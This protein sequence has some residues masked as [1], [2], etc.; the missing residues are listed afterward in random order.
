[1]TE[2]EVWIPVNEAIE[3]IRQKSRMS[4]GAAKVAL[5]EACAS[6]AVRAAERQFPDYLPMLIP[7]H[8][9]QDADIDLDTGELVAK[10][11]DPNE[12]PGANG[13]LVFNDAD[14]RYWLT[15]WRASS[16]K[17]AGGKRTRII[18]QLAE[19]FPNG[20][21]PEPGL[22][23]RKD[24]RAQLLERDPMLRPLDEETLKAS[25]NEFNAGR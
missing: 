24:L 12:R 4:I 18:K 13:I 1:M 14:L 15:H 17:Q 20:P 7:S 5:I 8:A 21:V 9:W 6:R 16:N 22:C 10:D 11:D 25:I 2:K 19:M 3:I 23:P